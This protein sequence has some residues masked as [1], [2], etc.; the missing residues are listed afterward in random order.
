MRTTKK[1]TVLSRTTLSTAGM[2]AQGIARFI[3]T[4]SIGRVLGP[5]AL[6]NASALLSIA[7]YFALLFPAGLGVAASRYLP[8]PGLAG[9]AISQLTRWFWVSSILLGLAAAPAAYLVVGDI[10]SAVSC[11]VL[12]ITYNA[13]VFTRGVMMGEDRIV[14]A[15]FADFGSSAIAVTSLLA[16]LLA[17]AH[18]ALLLPLS[19]GYIVF[20]L[21]S[22]PLTHPIPAT[23]GERK[24][25]FRFVRDA[26]IAGVATGGLLPA[27]MI[28]VRAFD[29][30]FQAGLFAAAL[31]LATPASL[32]S[33]AANQVLIPH[34]ARM[35]SKPR[36]M[37]AEQIRLFMF[38]SLFFV[39]IFGLIIVFAPWVLAQLYGEEYIDGSSS[40][41]ALLAVVFMISSTSSPSAYLLATGRQKT[42]ALIW[43]IAFVIGT[44]TMAVTSPA[45]G[46]WGAILGFVVGGAGGSI[47]VITYALIDRPVPELKNQS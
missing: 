10:F 7:A 40:M 32:I 13:Y 42:F 39:F 1:Q 15:T 26:T 12:V 38:S 6:G 47:A 35:N 14:R 20:S 11:A 4:L 37:H 29:N 28:F 43:V 41:Q 44:I 27:T 23:P 9:Q 30:S 34:Y 16:V 8:E 22:R 17:G 24:V 19:A 36:E 31:S 33:Q 5:E 46:T 2:A 18:W 25:M 45:I 3:Y 21:L